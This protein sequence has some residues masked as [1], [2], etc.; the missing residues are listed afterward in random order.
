M[1]DD[2][3]KVAVDRV[4]AVNLYEIAD[5][6]IGIGLCGIVWSGRRDFHLEGDVLIDFVRRVIIGL[7]AGGASPEDV[8]FV[9]P[10]N[11]RGL[12]HFGADSPEEI[13]EGVVAAWVAAGMPAP[14]WGDWRFNTPRNRALLDEVVESIAAFEA[15][16]TK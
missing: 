11:P 15:S 16:Q 12:A 1:N 14:E 13:A 9:T 5:D 6:E 3:L 10:D 2:E 4:V 8:S 7:V